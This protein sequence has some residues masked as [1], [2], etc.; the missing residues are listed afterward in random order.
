MRSSFTARRREAL[1]YRGPGGAL[2]RPSS[3]CFLVVVAGVWVAAIVFFGTTLFGH[4][5]GDA[6]SYVFSFLG[7]GLHAQTAEN[8]LSEVQLLQREV[9]EL[10]ARLTGLDELRD[11]VPRPPLE[12]KHAAEAEAEAAKA[13]K[14]P[15]QAEAGGQKKK[16]K[17]PQPEGNAASATLDSDTSPLPLVDPTVL[18]RSKPPFEHADMEGLCAHKNDGDEDI[19]KRVDVWPEA[20]MGKPRILC[21]SYTLSSAHATAVKNVRMTWG[22]RC[23]GYVAMSDLL[24]PAVP[25]IDI[26]HQG[27][28]AYG[29]MWQKIRSIWVYLHKHHLHDYDYFVSGG[30][31]SSS[32]S[33]TSGG[34]SCRRRLWPPRSTGRSPSSWAG[35]SAPPATLSPSTR[36]VLGLC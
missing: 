13:K 35:P 9:E 29:N 27:P 32:S 5:K 15:A 10:E 30:T 17:E 22:Q 7:R 1:G 26:K 24:D 11:A 25:S 3:T 4:G 8:P 18:T 28:E 2:C 16:K 19:L 23:D 21:F 34:T 12:L 31:T 14:A 33:R 20:Q 6:A 36:A